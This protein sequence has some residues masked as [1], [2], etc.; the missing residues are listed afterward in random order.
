MAFVSQFCGSCPQ[1]VAGSDMVN[2][3]AEGGPAV[4]GVRYTTIPT[5]YDELVVPWQSGLLDAPNATNRVLQEVCPND[6][7]EHA[8]LAVDPVVAQLI[9]NAL[10]PRWR[11][12]PRA[13]GPRP[14]RGPPLPMR[15]GRTSSKP[16]SERA[17]GATGSGGCGCSRVPEGAHVRVT[18]RARRSARRSC[19]FG[20]RTERIDRTRLARS[21]RPLFRRRRLA[22]GTTIRVDVVADA[23][24]GK[25]FRLRVGR[26][27][28]ARLRSSELAPR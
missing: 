26:R 7:S 17:S 11:S 16:P 15:P 28:G 21:L 3:L 25:R 18:C 27:G 5:I 10:D 20:S 1:F 8:A 19:P 13:R 22:S 4:R 14:S 9:F 12:S 2:K 24:R 23:V 6:T